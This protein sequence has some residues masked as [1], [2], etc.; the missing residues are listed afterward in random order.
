MKNNGDANDVSK[1]S[2]DDIKGK[3]SELYIEQVL[4]DG[5]QPPPTE[6]TAPPAAEAFNGYQAKAESLTDHQSR[7]NKD[8]LTSPQVPPMAAPIFPKSGTQLNHRP[9]IRCTASAG[10]MTSGGLTLNTTNPTF[11]TRHTPGRQH[12][13]P[14][15]VR[16][17]ILQEALFGNPEADQESLSAIRK[18]RA[19][20]KQELRN[21][22]AT[23]AQLRR[24]LDVFAV[25]CN[26][27]GAKLAEK[28]RASE[29][30][31]QTS[32]SVE[33]VKVND[34]GD[35]EGQHGNPLK[36][37]GKVLEDGA[38]DIGV[39][40]LENGV[41]RPVPRQAS[42]ASELDLPRDFDD[43]VVEDAEVDIGV[44]HLEKGLVKAVP[45]EASLTH[46]LGLPHD[47]EEGI[48]EDPDVDVGALHLEN[49]VIKAAPRKATLTSELGLPHSFEER[50][51]EDPAVNVGVLH[52]K[53]GV[54]KTVPRQASLTSEL[55]LPREIE[56]C[57]LEDP[58][59]DIGVLQLDGGVLK[60][61]SKE[62]LASINS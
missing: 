37:D 24:Q 41:L 62:A 28:R 13:S 5:R 34:V 54:L 56:E 2:K 17:A 38:G 31:L 15:G 39:L 44:L 8:C 59:A 35:Y 22:E 11:A 6:D 46:A 33:V 21:I 27:L 26:G 9:L 20:A 1:L 23:N 43:S 29:A 50:I 53:Y 58:E 36:V 25:E 42:L 19:L 18:A 32:D 48:V 52:M 7:S 40:K 10:E 14:G 12:I 47:F 49:G 3:A 30:D 55:N 57:V 61:V 4:V 60:A 45:R 51:L 16:R